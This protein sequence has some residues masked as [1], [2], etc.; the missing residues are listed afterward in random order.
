MCVR[1]TPASVVDLNLRLSNW[2]RWM[3]SFLTTR[4][5]SLSAMTFS[6]SLPKVLRSTIGQKDLGWSYTILFSLGI[7]I[8]EEC[9]KWLGQCPRLMHTSVMLIML[10]RQS[11]CLRMVLRCRHISLS[12]LGAD[13]LLHLII[14]RLNSSIENSSQ[15]VVVLNPISLR[16]SV[17][18]WQ[19][20]TVLKVAWRALYKLSGVRHGWLSYLMALIV[21][22][23]CL[24][25]QFINS[26]GPQLLFATSWIFMSKYNLLVFLITFL[27]FFQFSR[28]LDIL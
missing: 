9:L 24:L 26:Q 14:A 3:K 19:W 4:N 8:V 27:K 16:I 15:V 12:G 22:S 2:L 5:W 11:S 10:E 28:L 23:L 6:M 20:S 18:T 13:E 25:I 21:G 17:S 7:I 1:A